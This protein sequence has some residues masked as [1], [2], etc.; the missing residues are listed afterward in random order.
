M[1]NL[2]T[3]IDI[4]F[5]GSDI[6]SDIQMSLNTGNF[7]L[8]NIEYNNKRYEIELKFTFFEE[9]KATGLYRF[10]RNDNM[11]PFVM[12]FDDE[13]KK[14]KVSFAKLSHSMNRV[15]V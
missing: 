7:V 4:T 11:Q 3:C 9:K 12:F 13:F 1:L 15:I 2:N 6:R 14:S 10:G 5:I 8:F